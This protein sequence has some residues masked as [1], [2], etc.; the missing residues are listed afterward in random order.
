M[1][2]AA[3]AEPPTADKTAIVGSLLG[4][5]VGDAIG[6]PRE[7]LSPRR[8]ERLF[9]APYRHALLFGHGMVSD[10]T[11]HACLVAEA[12]LVADGDPQR[13][14]RHLARGL[15][16]WLLGL[17]AGV[18]FATL[19]SILRLWCGVPPH[20]SG[21]F[22]AGNGPAMRSPL[23]GAYFPAEPELMRDYVLRSTRITHSDPLAFH[24]ALAVALAAAQSSRGRADLDALCAELIRL[25]PEVTGGPLPE[26][27]Q[28]AAASAARN[29]PVSSF[30]SKLGCRQ[31]IGGYIGHTVP[32]VLQTWLRHADDYAGGI[33]ELLQAAGDT[34]TTCAIYGGI[35]GA[36]VGKD[37]IPQAW[38]DG[39]CEWPKTLCWI[40]RL[41]TALT[42]PAEK[43]RPGY[44][45]P[46]LLLRNL[47]FLLVVLAH[48]LRRLAPPY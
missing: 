21:V 30:A 18:G 42:D 43:S 46:G 7:G 26:L 40:E 4:T 1:S 15:R 37:G 5:A 29:E 27:L 13:F 12:L 32:C 39:I 45:L 23:L 6:L 22:S 47:L 38:R 8:A 41:G 44:F 10:D 25:Q 28:Q 36:R 34:D 14:E 19:R 16:H 3:K 24:G 31:G 17:P 9:P 2:F 20:R 33:G 35:V 48:G 11:E